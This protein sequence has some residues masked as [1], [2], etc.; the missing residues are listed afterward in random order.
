MWLRDLYKSY[1]GYKALLYTTDGC[2]YSYFTCGAIPDVYA[3]VDFG[4]SINDGKYLPKVYTS[5]VAKN[6]KANGSIRNES[7]F[8]HRNVVYNIFPLNFNKKN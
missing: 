8:P 6:L 1:V 2:G 7:H 4:A 3:T 5:G